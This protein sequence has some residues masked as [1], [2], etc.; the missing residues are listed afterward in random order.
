MLLPTIARS[1][2]S[3]VA[4]SGSTAVADSADRAD[5]PEMN[6]RILW[7]SPTPRQFS[8][9]I[10]IT[11][12]ELQLVRNLSLQE[13]SIGRIKQR[14]AQEL[15]ILPHSASTFGGADLKVRAS[16]DA[17]VEI[18]FAAQSDRTA[19]TKKRIS[20]SDLLRGPTIFPLDTTG[21]R[22]AIDRPIQDRIRLEFDRELQVIEVRQS[23]HA[24]IG[25]FQT[26]LPQGSYTLDVSLVH[27]ESQ[28]RENLLAESVRIDEDGN[29]EAIDF[30]LEIPSQ[31]GA[32][33]I[34]VGL[35][36]KRLIP[37]V[38]GESQ[39]VRR[40]DFVAF[41]PNGS[42][43]TITQWNDLFT[44]NA[45]R[46]IASDGLH[47]IQSAW[48]S[49]TSDS[50]DA[51]LGGAVR[52]AAE[53]HILQNASRSPAAL[54]KERS[55]QASDP[56]STE[57]TDSRATVAKGWSLLGLQS[58]QR[59][60]HS[61]AESP[62][63]PLAAG[64]HS[65]RKAGKFGKRPIQSSSTGSAVSAPGVSA[66]AVS[67]PAVSHDAQAESHANDPGS[68]M[69][70]TTQGH[71][72]QNSKPAIECLWMAPGAWVEVPLGELDP[73]RPH[74]LIV[75]AP[76]DQPNRLNLSILTTRATQQSTADGQSD[77]LGNDYQ[78]SE[79][80]MSAL[81]LEKENTV[82]ANN[83]LDEPVQQRKS[84]TTLKEYTF[85]FWPRGGPVSVRLMNLQSESV[86]SV[87][88]IRVQQAELSEAYSRFPETAW[89]DNRPE[90]N[91]SSRQSVSSGLFGITLDKPL[92]SSWFGSPKTKDPQTGRFYETWHTYDLAC[93]RL[94]TYMDWCQANLLVVK[95]QA[96]GSAIFP[97]STLSPTPRLDSGIF[98]SDG[99]SPQHKDAVELLLRH[100]QRAGIRVILTLDLDS[101]LD[102]NSPLGGLGDSGIHQQ[103]FDGKS[104]ARNYDPLHPSVQ[105]KLL[106]V[107]DEIASKFGSNSAFLGLQV[108]IDND[109]PLVYR[110]DMWGFHSSQLERFSKETQLPSPSL[111][112]DTTRTTST[113][114]VSTS[115]T[116]FLRWR[117]QKLTQFYEQL[118][119]RIARHAP[120][121]KL[122]LDTLRVWENSPD[123]RDF[124]NPTKIVR[125][126]AE[127]L[128]ALGIDTE[129]LAQNEHVVLL[130]G[131]VTTSRYTLNSDDWIRQ[132]ARTQGL[133]PTASP[134]AE[135]PRARSALMLLQPGEVTPDLETRNASDDGL[136]MP[137]VFPIRV[138]TQASLKRIIG[139]QVSN[140]DSDWIAVGSW[141]PLG[142]NIEDVRQIYGSLRRVHAA[143]ASFHTQ[144]SR[145]VAVRG[146]KSSSGDS[147]H[148][149]NSAIAVHIRRSET[150]AFLL[151]SNRS[152]WR[153]NCALVVQ[154]ISGSDATPTFI[155]PITANDDGNNDQP[156]IKREP[157]GEGRE[158]W[159]FELEPY[160]FC[161]L[162]IGDR[163]FEVLDT[164][165][166]PPSQ[167]VKRIE[168]QL[169]KLEQV[170][171]ETAD[172][173]R[174]KPLQNVFGGFEHW[175]NEF[176]TE[177]KEETPTPIAWNVS[178][179]PGVR[180]DRSSDFPHSGQYSLSIQ[181]QNTELAAW[182]HSREFPAPANGRLSLRAWLRSPTINS[183]VVV[184]LSIVGRSKTGQRFER[185]KQFGSREQGIKIANDWGVRPAILEVGDLPVEDLES[186]FVAIELIGKGH[187]WIDDVE[188][189]ESWLHADERVYLQSRMLVAMKELQRNNPLPAESLLSS[190]WGQYLS[191]YHP[192][193]QPTRSD[194]PSN[195]SPSSSAPSSE[196]RTKW[197]ATPS[198]FQQ[199][200]KAMVERWRR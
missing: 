196:V 53:Y 60:V 36:E 99:R 107:V 74:R 198:L 5:L 88:D 15:S 183:D 70:K 73:T 79:S 64:N 46:D 23:I 134:L 86:A 185:S 154:T 78:I 101:P 103:H 95:I 72:S 31:S 50:V 118:Q 19:P 144:S 104:F 8:G 160:E 2:E 29:F 76:V 63:N 176:Q 195:A 27:V 182:V 139:E 20:L 21:A 165:S 11:G 136:S 109:S 162:N 66:A 75:R 167:V 190:S 115:G 119:T 111:A 186:I 148:M 130:D 84:A 54:T 138:G 49:Q 56:T 38:L 83:K 113:E 184:R 39:V 127:H 102:F 30:P 189:L 98:F 40:Y 177:I 149:E 90:R 16:Q 181:N 89:H 48:L 25:G 6:V 59:V 85:F 197:D 117:A 156:L 122:C 91:S 94:V 45:I 69:D 175:S 129:Q 170:L 43:Q 62:W 123:K 33:S 112:G 55:S 152:P 194:V 110:G 178:A 34:E 37:N 155:D 128:L 151:L 150:N 143:N 200:R 187:V 133:N 35:Q 132:L 81:Q 18:E 142:Q 10:R 80:R 188:V 137:T 174:Q 58:T 93:Q 105:A 51:V 140:R 135:S 120:D 61:L 191:R 26:R 28:R 52:P 24:S 12:G 3:P 153:Q 114:E 157:A 82:L 68:S 172:P 13:D 96:D 71:T 147:S 42:I 164:V 124:A 9:T 199:F 192:S 161:S 145:L 106:S 163:N 57:L 100:C 180:V 14:T 158:N 97:S 141:L 131:D 121:A 179:M 169:R 17:A 1:Q 32:Y 171:N 193:M 146:A 166:A 108:Q 125:K 77:S 22:I 87:Y 92:L 41:D 4:G 67:A 44:K 65:V 159:L 116:A 173:T 168:S 126:P 7:G 47:W